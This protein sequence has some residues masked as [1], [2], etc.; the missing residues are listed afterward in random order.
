[1]SQRKSH[2]Q[3]VVELGTVNPNIEVLGNYVKGSNPVQCRCKV[4]GHVWMSRPNNLLSGFGCPVCG[5]KKR[6][7]AQQKTKEE[8]LQ[9]MAKIDPTIQVVGEYCGAQ[10]R[11][12]CA[13]RECGHTWSPL[14]TNLLAGKG[15][16][17]CS[18][19]KAG[20]K[21]MRTND[22]FVAV[23]KKLNPTIVVL[24]QF[25]GNSEK[26][27]CSCAVCGY[28]WRPLPSVL[29]R[30]SGCP[31]C[32]G[33]ERYTTAEFERKLKKINPYVSLLGRYQRTNEP[34]LCRC[35]LCGH[36]WQSTPNRLLHG[37]GCPGCRHSATSFFEQVVYRTLILILG[38]KN[39]I[40]HD[41]ETVGYEL[42]IF[43]PSMK[44]ALEPG[45]WKW[46]KNM[47][48]RD[49]EKRK[50]CAEMGIRLITIYT[51]YNETESPFYNDCLTTQRT[52]GLDKEYA[53]LKSFLSTLLV[54]CGIECDITESQFNS[55]TNEAYLAS[56]RK[57]TQLFKM[58]LETVLPSVI[59]LSEY[60]GA[61]NDISCKCRRCGYEWITQPHSLLAGHGC[62][63]CAAKER[64]LTFRK[65]PQEFERELCEINP[66]I[67]LLTQYID[68]KT[69]IHCKCAIC[70]HEWKQLPASLKKGRGCPI[71]RR[72]KQ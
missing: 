44:L 16:P 46:H 12:Q 39:V 63:Q 8:F 20:N 53:E 24:E 11:V 18:K 17:V 41:R 72:R 71:C 31:R 40:S 23:V 34:I 52:F 10:K 60:K 37:I 22:E 36:E 70:G 64:G 67:I 51:D 69:T 28:S 38:E 61:L 59:L 66:Q 9:E 19:K 2:E 55:I 65:S 14:A 1:M 25:H 50:L 45:S 54:L 62:M 26:L 47:V 21:R 5:V 4:C 58:E 68:S 42:D 33:N 57:S 35:E 49:V 7:K 3:F 48:D 29:L 43:V 27:R 56:R 13:C 6:S 15:C 30:G 32:A